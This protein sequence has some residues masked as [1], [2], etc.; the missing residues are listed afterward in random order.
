[1]RTGPRPALWLGMQGD[2]EARLRA[3]SGYH[4]RRRRRRWHRRGEAAS[5]AQIAERF[6]LGVLAEDWLAR[7]RRSAAILDD[8]LIGAVLVEAQTR[9]DM[10][11]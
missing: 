5:F 4:W 11:R 3:A 7:A 9:G 1:M 6:D 10:A 2:T 8:E